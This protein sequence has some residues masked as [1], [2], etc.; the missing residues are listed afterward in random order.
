MTVEATAEKTA[1]ELTEL[2]KIEPTRV[3]GVGTPANGFP[4]LMM[5]SIT[6]DPPVGPVVTEKAPS[7][8]AGVL[9]KAK[10]AKALEAVKG[11]LDGTIPVP[12]LAKDAAGYDESADIAG[13]LD[14]IA[15]I[16][17]LVCS[18][19]TALGT[20]RLEEIWDIQTLM[21]ALC[22]MRCFLGSEREQD[23]GSGA[24][25]AGGAPAADDMNGAVSYLAQSAA[26]QP[27]AEPEPVVGA[28]EPAAKK[29]GGKHAGK[30]A[31]KGAILTVSE[32]HDGGAA[33]TPDVIK[34]A[35]AEAVAASEDRL[36]T[37]EAQLAK[38]LAQPIPG[39]PHL[40]TSLNRAP[41]Q[42][43]RLAKAA[44]YRAIAAQ[45]SDPDTKRSY[46]DLAARE[47]GAPITKGTAE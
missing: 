22:A 4:I 30:K 16:S 7:R 46:L 18:E 27:A 21:D 34:Q 3:D 1:V 10:R 32:P 33:I 38:V 20:G 23:N 28:T 47:E 42:D 19:A 9:G 15:R 5:K 44:R 39:G 12:V 29:G 24:A 13:A 26:E 37:V 25:A 2:E 31:K 41:A 11:V 35:V 40:V 17:T 36:K 8:P 6:I 45:T 43:P 14:V